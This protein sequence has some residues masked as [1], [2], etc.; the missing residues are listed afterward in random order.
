M[1]ASHPRTRRAL[2]MPSAGSSRWSSGRAGAA[3]IPTGSSATTASPATTRRSACC[4]SCSRKLVGRS[5]SCPRRTE[6]SPTAAAGPATDLRSALEQLLH[7]VEG[8]HLRVH[9]RLDGPAHQQL[10]QAAELYVEP[11]GED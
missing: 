4:G 8:A 10:L 9:R 6:A 11:K 7:P 5:S 2:P 3:T 1:S